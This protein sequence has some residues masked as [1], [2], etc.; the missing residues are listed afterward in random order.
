MA[1]PDESLQLQAYN[2]YFDYYSR[3]LP[4]EDARVKELKEPRSQGTRISK[5]LQKPGRSREDRDN[6]EAGRKL[7][8]NNVMSAQ[9]TLWMAAEEMPSSESFAAMIVD[10]IVAIGTIH[11]EE[12]TIRALT[13]Q[14][15]ET[16][17]FDFNIPRILVHACNREAQSQIHQNRLDEGGQQS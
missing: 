7:A 10:T 14:V 11:A 1:T 2:L 8:H 5:W 17:E 9:D 3:N 16:L 13:Q 4:Y 12:T 6:I 15:R